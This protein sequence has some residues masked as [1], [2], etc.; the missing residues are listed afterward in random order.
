[1]KFFVNFTVKP[2]SCTITSR[3]IFTRH[4]LRVTPDGPLYRGIKKPPSIFNGKIRIHAHSCNILIVPS[5]ALR[6]IPKGMCVTTE[7][8]T[9]KQIG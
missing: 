3:R 9:A 7:N 8:M 2:V 5:T 6:D 4:C 1:M